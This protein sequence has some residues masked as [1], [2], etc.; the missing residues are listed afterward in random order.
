MKRSKFAIIRQGNITVVTIVY[1]AYGCKSIV[2]AI[3]VGHVY[4][5]SLLYYCRF[6]DKGVTGQLADCHC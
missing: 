4:K 1:A 2:I 5:L 3:Y 6:L